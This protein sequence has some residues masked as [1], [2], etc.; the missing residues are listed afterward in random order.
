MS[1]S[2]QETKKGGNGGG[3]SVCPE[4]E[5]GFGSGLLGLQISS[6]V[7]LRIRD[8]GVEL[9]ELRSSD[10]GC[11]CEKELPAGDKS[12][13]SHPHPVASL[14]T[15]NLSTTPFLAGKSPVASP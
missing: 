5:S 15:S 9:L 13:P 1:H 2:P 7:G 6:V 8:L 14:R 12:P 3:S 10:L 11:C 4:P